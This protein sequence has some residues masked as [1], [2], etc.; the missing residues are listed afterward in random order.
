LRALTSELG[1]YAAASAA[2]LAVDI[3]VLTALVSGAGWQYLPAAILSFIVGGVFLYGVC[4]VFVFQF[5]RIDN[6]ALELPCFIG[7]GLAGLVVNTGVM[8]V[9]VEG[10]HAHYLIAKAG[11]AACTFTTNFLLR[12]R[13]LFTPS[14]PS[15]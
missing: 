9:I 11:A 8:F 15:G 12:R 1:I 5:R 10:V 7:L 2:A 4:V 3:G 13:V 6:P 14:R